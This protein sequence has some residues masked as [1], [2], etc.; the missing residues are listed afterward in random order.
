MRPRSFPSPTVV[1]VNGACGSSPS[2]CRDCRSVL[3]Q[4]IT[5]ST[6]MMRLLLI[7]IAIIVLIALMVILFQRELVHTTTWLSYSPGIRFRGDGPGFSAT[8][9]RRIY[10]AVYEGHTLDTSLSSAGEPLPIPRSCPLAVVIGDEQ[11]RIGH[12]TSEVMA[13]LGA[14]A[15]RGERD[16]TWILRQDDCA[17]MVTMDRDDRPIKFTFGGP[18]LRCAGVSI[19][20]HDK[21]TIQLPISRRELFKKIGRPDR[22]IHTH[23]HIV[24]P[25]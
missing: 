24:G 10:V 8:E 20:W 12:L 22:I 21:T 9:Y 11:Y 23:R 17:V 25:H 13:K 16:V 15:S 4:V 5:S 18:S 3:A 6:T 19:L 14:E 7:C 2:Q 1:L